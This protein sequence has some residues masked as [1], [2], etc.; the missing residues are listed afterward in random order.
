MEWRQRGQSFALVFAHF[1][2]RSFYFPENDSIKTTKIAFAKRKAKQKRD[3]EKELYNNL[4]TDK[5][6]YHPTFRIQSK[7]KWIVL[8]INFKKSLQVELRVLCSVIKLGGTNSVK[9]NSRYFY[10]LD[11]RNCKKKH[12]TS[13]TT[14]TNTILSTPN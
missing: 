6:N 9:K 14:E 12:I 11:R 1:S 5:K 10:N 13:L 2:F 8:K 3:Q 7:P 4:A